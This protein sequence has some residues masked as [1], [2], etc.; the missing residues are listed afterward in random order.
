[1]AASLRSKFKDFPEY[2]VAGVKEV[3]FNPYESNGG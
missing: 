2:Q 3:N 1:M